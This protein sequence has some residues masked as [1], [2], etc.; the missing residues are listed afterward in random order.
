MDKQDN[1]STCPWT[2]LDPS[3]EG[4]VVHDFLTTRLSALMSALRRQLTMPYASEFDLSVSE[5]RILSLVAH[6]G[7][8]PFS[9]LV[10]QSTS[11]K[12]LVSRTIRLLQ[13]RNL[14]EIGPES[15][16]TRKRIACSITPEGQ[17]L[18]DKVIVIARRRQAEIICS[19]TREE[20]ETLFTAVTK[21]QRVLE[22]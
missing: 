1:Q 5:W 19:L 9:K 16:S 11:D 12:A 15:E 4:L 10:V 3:G 6:A 2:D 13:N 17:A 18:Y 20:R 7:T 8:L 14:I 21:L 22:E